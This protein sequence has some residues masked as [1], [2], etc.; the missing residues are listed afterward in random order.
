MARMNISVR[1]DLK[2]S[3][4]DIGNAL[5][6]SA[7]AQKAFE[8][9]LLRFTS[10]KMATDIDGAVDR[11]QASRKLTAIDNQESGYEAGY[12]WAIRDA[13]YIELSRLAEF[14]PPNDTG[15]LSSVVQSVVSGKDDDGDNSGHL[16]FWNSVGLADVPSNEFVLGFVRGAGE[17]W[18]KVKDR[19][20]GPIGA[21]KLKSEKS[22]PHNQQSVPLSKFRGVSYSSLIITRVP[23]IDVCGRLGSRRREKNEELRTGITVKE[24]YTAVNTKN[25]EYPASRNN[26]EMNLKVGSIVLTTLDGRNVISG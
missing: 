9:E 14:K 11:L 17:I 12:N 10:K 3:M 8:V 2:G 15:P 16:A 18:N 1:D 26:I 22:E 4:D 19:V 20:P 23:D 13:E 21:N 6:W 7:I 24:F 25:P 5:N